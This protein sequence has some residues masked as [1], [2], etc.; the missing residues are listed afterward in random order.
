VFILGFDFQGI[1]DLLNNVYADTKNYRSSSDPATY[2]GNWMKQTE[3]IFNEY[4]KVNFIR[5]NEPGAYMKRDW[6]M[7]NNFKDIYYD[8]F[9]EI[10]ESF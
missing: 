6:Q 8:E 3:T 9:N 7:I 2:F 10:L 5:V 1:N 4:N